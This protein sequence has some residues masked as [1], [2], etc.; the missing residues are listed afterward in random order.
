[1]TTAFVSTNMSITAG[2]AT[3]VHVDGFYV[4]PGVRLT[5]NIGQQVSGPLAGVM[6]EFGQTT[7]FIGTGG[8]LYARYDMSVLA[9]LN[10][11]ARCP[12]LCGRYFILDAAARSRLLADMGITGTLSDL[13]TMADDISGV[14]A[15]TYQGRP[16][17][18]AVAPSFGHGAYIIVSAAAQCYLL[19][20]VDPGQFELAFS[21][22][23]QVPVPV[24]PPPADITDIYS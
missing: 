5:V 17:F 24:A 4:W 20:F 23:N 3:S 1:M 19:F 14:T 21:Q 11:A 7:S 6:T 8:R 9:N 2:T 10:E 13:Q 22:W 16:A 12:S 15:T 18:R